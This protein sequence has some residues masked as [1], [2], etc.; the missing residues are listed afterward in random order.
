MAKRCR[1][2][3]SA[4]GTAFRGFPDKK[5][6]ANTDDAKGRFCYSLSDVWRIENPSGVWMRR[7]GFFRRNEGTENNMEPANRKNFYG[8]AALAP[9]DAIR[10]CLNGSFGMSDVSTLISAIRKDRR[11]ALSD[12]ELLDLIVEALEDGL[13]CPGVPGAVGRPAFRAARHFA[14][15][16]PESCAV[17][18]NSLHPTEWG[19]V[20]SPLPAF[21]CRA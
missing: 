9:V 19:R 12:D 17:G 3:R 20:S 2:K 4:D 8:L 5:P 11:I 16:R 10:V 6:S 18:A 7:A 14:F 21:P 13:D 1:G 15:R